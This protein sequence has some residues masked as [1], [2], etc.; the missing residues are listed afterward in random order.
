MFNLKK[1]LCAIQK[2]VATEKNVASKN[3]VQNVFM[4]NLPV[5]E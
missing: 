3:Q 2:N 1:K 5:V 4:L